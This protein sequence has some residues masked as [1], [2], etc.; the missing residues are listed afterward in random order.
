MRSPRSVS[1]RLRNL[2][3]GALSGLLDG[4][5]D[6]VRPLCTG[7]VGKVTLTGRSSRACRRIES[8]GE[9]SEVGGEPRRHRCL[10]PDI[11]PHPPPSREAPGGEP[12]SED[13]IAM[14]RPTAA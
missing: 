12:P 2:P 9:A 4:P 7:T 10:T 5:G 6:S 1:G 13:T 14:P 11:Y 8:I 3:T